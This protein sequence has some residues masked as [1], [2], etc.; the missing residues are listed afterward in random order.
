MLNLHKPRFRTSLR[1]D[2]KMNYDTV[3]KAEHEVTRS[4]A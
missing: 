3:S 2:I 4:E 1:N